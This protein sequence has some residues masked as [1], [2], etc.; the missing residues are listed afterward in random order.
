MYGDVEEQHEPA[1]LS[2]WRECCRGYPN[3]NVGDKDGQQEMVLAD[4]GKDPLI[5]LREIIKGR[6]EVMVVSTDHH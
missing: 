6:D 4:E 5:N 3:W 1:L 2:V